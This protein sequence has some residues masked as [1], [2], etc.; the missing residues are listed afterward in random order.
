M[1]DLL[2]KIALTL[3]PKVGAVTAKNLVSYCGGAKE[4]FQSSKKELIKIPGIGATIAHNIL[5]PEVMKRAELEMRFVEHN[6]IQTF[7]YLDADYPQRL[8]PLHDAPVVLYYKG[9]TDLNQKRIVSIVGTRKPTSYGKI[10]CEKIVE[11]LKAYDVL[12]VSG[13]AMG[14]DVIAHRKCIEEQ[15]PT[16]GVLGHGMKM[17]YPAAHRKI[18]ANMTMNG[19]LLTEFASSVGAEKEHFPMRNRIVA[20]MC[21]ALIV[22][23]TKNKGG[24]VISVEMANNYSKDVF[25]IP[26]RINDEYSAGCNRL[27]KTHRAALLESVDDLAYVMQWDEDKTSASRQMDLFQ[28]LDDTEKNIINILKQ[29]EEQGIDELMIQTEL[30]STK[31]AAVMLELEFKG[32]VKTIPGKRYSLV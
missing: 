26:G 7:F 20:G 19:G 15:L 28:E 31:I 24:S 10:S 17:I 4:V 6:S 11:Q 3:I 12:V 13:L 27:I 2:Y 22:V 14:I 23:Q 1:D 30:S 29:D 9:N 25:A 18:A 5:D 16:V 21:D 8:K 32:L